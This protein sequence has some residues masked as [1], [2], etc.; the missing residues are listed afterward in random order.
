M[1]NGKETIGIRIPD[2]HYVLSLLEKAGPM[3][4]TS[5]NLSNYPNTTTTKEV[6][7][8]LDGRIDIVVD[9]KTTDNIAST[10]IDVSRQDIQILRVGK[11]T[12]K[13]IEEAIK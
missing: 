13:E 1:T 4:V 11:I 7:A 3:L 12:N 10:V 6:L 5:A 9:G 2:S 8:Q